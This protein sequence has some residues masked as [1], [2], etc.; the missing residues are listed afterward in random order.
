VSARKARL[1]LD[2]IRGKPWRKRW[3]R[4]STHRAPRRGWSR[5]CCAGG[6]EREHNY[7]VR[8]LDD[9]RV[10]QAYAD[11]GPVL[12]RVQPRRWAARSRSAPHEPS[13]DRVS[14]EVKRR[15]RGACARTGS[16]EHAAASARERPAARRGA[17]GGVRPRVHRSRRQ[18]RPEAEGEKVDDG[19]ENTSDRFRL[20]VTRTWSSRWFATKAYA[21]LLH[22]DV[23]NPALHQGQLYTRGFAKIDIER[24][25]IAR[26]ITIRDVRVPASSSPQGFR[27]SRS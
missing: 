13:H 1:V 27:R 22:E 2:Q 24:S 20:G 23:K 3:R 26:S 14:D 5:R 9:L 19:P 17:A 6:G 18:R 8:G 11:G 4:S 21:N 16:S 10:V 15:R 7:Q 12:K 25:P